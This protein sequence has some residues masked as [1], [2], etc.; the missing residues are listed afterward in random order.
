M[1]APLRTCAAGVACALAVTAGPA[2]ALAPAPTT[3]GHLVTRHGSETVDV[4]LAHTDVVLRVDGMLVDATVTQHFRNPYADK[5]EAVYLF[6]LPTGAAVDDLV[7]TS[8]SRTIHGQLAERAAA[9][10]TYE[11]AKSK[12]QVAA[13]MTEERPNLFTQNVANLE[14]H[15][16]IDITLHYVQRLDYVDGGYE[17]VFPM[18]APPR[19]IPA[20]GS[21]TEVLAPQTL[22]PGQRSSHDISL[23]AI[24]DAGVPIVQVV[25][26]SHQVAIVHPTTR[27]ATVTLAPGDTVPNK[28]FILDYKVAGAAPATGL[29]AGDGSFVLVAQPP[30]TAPPAALTP[31]EIIFMLDTSSSMRGAPL[32]KAKDLVRGVLGTLR[33]DDTFQVVRFADTAAALAASPIAN[34]PHNVELALRW[35]DALVAGGST[36]VTAGLDTAFSQPHDARRMRI[37]V[38]VGD[39]Y[40]GD[41]DAILARTTAELGTARLFCFGV[42]SAVNRYLLEELARAGRGSLQVVRPDADTQ[43]ATAQFVRRVDAPLVTDLSIDW[44]GLPVTDVTPSL[45]DLFLGAPLVIAGHYAHAAHATVTLHG[46]Q[47]GQ[48]ISL[49]LDVTLP[50]R[51]GAHRVIGSLWARERIDELSRQYV[52][53]ADKD[54]RAEILKLSLE[55]HLL[56]RFTAFVA[57]DDSHITAGGDAR[58]VAVP[59]EVPEAVQGIGPAGQYGGVYGGVL[60]SGGYGYIGS[61]AGESVGGFGYGVG[62]GGYITTGAG[63]GM[64]GG[65]GGLHAHVVTEPTFTLGKPTVTGDLDVAIIRR[66]LKRNREKL[67]YCYEK[68]LL[69]TPALAGEVVLQFTIS[70]EGA[71]SAST[72]AGVSGDVS[73]CMASVVRGL[74]FPK[75]KGGGLVDVR[76]PLE[77]AP[78]SPKESSPAKETTP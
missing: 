27:T 24:I 39:G 10:R 1:T 69:A 63:Y 36:E 60:G 43:A 34:R 50:A 64:G 59:V 17:L 30:A 55:S 15:A 61:S 19:Y 26:P 72:A 48:R 44:A 11:V 28:D 23:T 62:G 20:T 66:Y 29:L 7:I 38:F 40:V 71:V 76:F 22:P 4:P 70:A 73:T 52:R 13:L 8:G 46:T 9:T 65:F 47:A 58:K 16:E 31:R 68:A 14:P 33:A 6:P 67:Q 18:V 12:G 3:E 56:T 49:P 54:V 35:V 21:Y 75:P 51:D 45:P 78:P 42:G 57:V 77:L 37:V 2:Y 53:S 41:E 25:S 74:A 32:V 5:I